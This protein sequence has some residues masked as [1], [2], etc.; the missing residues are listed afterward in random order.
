MKL[1][2]RG[3]QQ[4][5]QAP[6]ELNFGRKLHPRKELPFREKPLHSGFARSPPPRPLRA[7]TLAAHYVTPGGRTSAATFGKWMVG[8]LSPAPGSRA[9]PKD[10]G[11]S[12]SSPG[13]C[14]FSLSTRGERGQ[15]LQASRW[16]VDRS[17]GNRDHPGSGETSRRRCAAAL[18]TRGLGGR[19]PR[20]PRGRGAHGPECG[21]ATSAF[22]CS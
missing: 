1:K 9:A 16:G 5:S 4:T 20:R 13:R 21:S 3:E 17:R 8:G 19:G 15:R 7:P 14:W 10:G 18:N 12:F 22:Q 2:A 11:P 6:A